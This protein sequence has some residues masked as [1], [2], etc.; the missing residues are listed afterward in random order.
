[1]DDGDY[2]LIIVLSNISFILLDILVEK[3]DEKIVSQ[4]INTN[5]PL[6]NSKTKQEETELVICSDFLDRKRFAQ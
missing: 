1:M 2:Y 6:I 4:N 5:V 3:K